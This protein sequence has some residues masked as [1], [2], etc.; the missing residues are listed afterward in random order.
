M[1]LSIYGTL[2]SEFARDSKRLSINYQIQ[3]SA[4]PVLLEGGGSHAFGQTLA[5]VGGDRLIRIISKND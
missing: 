3:I 4:M 1:L 2:L 5:Y